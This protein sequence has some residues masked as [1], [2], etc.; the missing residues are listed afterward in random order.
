MS[1]D[2]STYKTR[3]DYLNSK[4]EEHCFQFHVWEDSFD[5]Y[6]LARQS[7]SQSSISAG[8]V[9]YKEDEPF[10]GM[11]LWPE[12]KSESDSDSTGIMID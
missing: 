11:K 3:V 12:T 1:L 4:E 2:F 8:W 10:I 7:A 6:L 5:I 9:V